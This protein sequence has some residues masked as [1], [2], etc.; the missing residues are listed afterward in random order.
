MSKTLHIQIY[1]PRIQANKSSLEHC[2]GLSIILWIHIQNS[3][4]PVVE[5]CRSMSRTL[6]PLLIMRHSIINKDQE[7][8]FV[9]RKQG[10]KNQKNLR[11]TGGFLIDPAENCS[12]RLQQYGPLG[13]AKKVDK[14]CLFSSSTFVSFFC[15]MF[16][17]IR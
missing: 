7:Y 16:L 12:L 15:Q 14:F 13:P 4:D 9:W 6:E 11:P 2:R 8:R 5:P 10:L 3:T 17:K 1:D